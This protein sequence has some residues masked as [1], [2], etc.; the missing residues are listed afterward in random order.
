MVGRLPP[1]RPADEC[2][3]RC[4][5]AWRDAPT[6]AKQQPSSRGAR[7]SFCTRRVSRPAQAPAALPRGIQKAASV[8]AA[9]GDW[10]AAEPPFHHLQRARPTLG[11]LDW[12]SAR[13]G[14]VRGGQGRPVPGWGLAARTSFHSMSNRRRGRAPRLR[15]ARQ[16]H[17]GSGAASRRLHGARAARGCGSSNL[18]AVKSYRPAW[19]TPVPLAGAVDKC[20]AAGTASTGCQAAATAGRH[21]SG[22]GDGWPCR[23]GRI[24]PG[25]L[26]RQQPEPAARWPFRDV[27]WRSGGGR[28]EASR[29][30]ARPPA[31]HQHLEPGRVRAAGTPWCSRPRRR[32]SRRDGLANTDRRDAAWSRRK[33]FP[34]PC[35]R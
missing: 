31:P 33:A 30:P 11:P 9:A 22:R 18:P 7:P 4:H 12:T 10:L 19:P 14:R 5:R 35:G 32:P 25:G 27:A 21:V 23:G 29:V 8:G 15:R 20:I 3:H 26:R 6:L 2:Q 28:G 17:R 1:A 13:V 24:S 34:S 16:S